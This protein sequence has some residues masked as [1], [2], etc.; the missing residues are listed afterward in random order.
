MLVAGDIEL[1]DDSWFQ[2]IAAWQKPLLFLAQRKAFPKYCPVERP[3]QQ[4]HPEHP[5]RTWANLKNKALFDPFQNKQCN[6][7]WVMEVRKY[8]MVKRSQLLI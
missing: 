4:N 2:Y 6:N 1:I 8:E 7:R 5:K 3:T